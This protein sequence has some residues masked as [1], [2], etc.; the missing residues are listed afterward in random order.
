[1]KDRYV[2]CFLV[3]VFCMFVSP[4]ITKASCDYQRK[5]ELSKIAS[6]VQVNYSYEVE[7]EYPV[8][9]IILNNITDDIYVEDNYGNVFTNSE[10][11]LTYTLGAN[12]D[13]IIYSKDNNCYSEKLLTKYVKTPYYNVYY[14][15]AICND[16]SNKLCGMWVD[17]SDMSYADFVSNVSSFEKTKKNSTIIENKTKKFDILFF[18]KIGTVVIAI[19]IFVCI[20]N[21]LRKRRSI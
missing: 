2:K 4:L 13:F 14:S 8:M 3:F 5:A 9:N 19:L 18:A 1:M 20:L 12:I 16:N 17:T 10:N 11:I 7:N 21:I 15:D 6:N